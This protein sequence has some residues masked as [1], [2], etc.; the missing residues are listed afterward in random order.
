VSHN[1]K[2]RRALLID[3]SWR[4]VLISA[5]METMKQ[6]RREH[7]ISLHDEVE[8]RDAWGTEFGAIVFARINV[9]LLALDPGTLV[10]L[11]YGGL[12]RSDVS[13]Q[14]EAVVE[15]L[16]KHRPRLLFI[17]TQLTD[18]DMRDNLAIAL[19]RRGEMLLVRGKGRH[20]IVLGKRLTAEHQS[21]LHKVWALGGLVSSDLGDAKLSTASSRLALLWKAGLIERV[22]GT[23][24]TGGRE[25]RYLP[26][27]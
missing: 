13:F 20:P 16:R 2:R 7:S 23:S 17:A 12:E 8:G 24:V 5:S 18:P 15:T 4:P 27:L 21:T 1:A 9:R 11:D 14:R 26:I 6:T 22:E 19:D 3:Q 10:S 25:H